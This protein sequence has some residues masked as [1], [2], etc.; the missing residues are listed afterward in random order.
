[1]TI[2]GGWERRSWS[3]RLHAWRDRLF[4]SHRFRRFAA[5]FPLTRPI[6]RKRAKALFDL[7]TGFVHSQVLLACVRLRLFEHLREA[8]QTLDDLARSLDLPRDTAE[9]LLLA[10]CSLE[11]VAR[12]GEERFG[13]GE[14]GAAFLGS[15]G[16][17]LMVEHHAM[18]Y[19]DLADPVALL[20][21]EVDGTAL[22]R[23][24]AYAGTERA[25]ELGGAAVADYSQL[26]AATLP[27]IAADILDAYPVDRH[28]CLMDVGG[29][30]GA[31]LE[32]VAACAPDLEL[33]L[34]DLPAVVER[35]RQRFEARGLAGRLEVHGGDVHSDALPKVADLVTLVR[36]IHDHDDEA[37]L[38]ILKAVRRAL[39]PGGTLLLAEPMAG[40]PGTEAM[41][42][43][44]FGFYFLAMGRGRVRSVDQLAGM[45]RAAGYAA[46]EPLPTRIPLLVSMIKATVNNA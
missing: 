38:G 33:R 16:L 1:M 45:L 22:Q 23:Y 26:M 10:A 21:G 39:P 15:P 2:A 43:A 41:A 7:C 40:M 31:F 44:Y 28:R 9:R 24:W 3:D 6:A 30:E 5:R 34:F 27:M 11:L 29:G 20:R 19:R 42:A 12:R 18:L 36:I 25:S 35:A 17:D 14:Q 8:P 32:A 4:I 37:A 46:I 13:L